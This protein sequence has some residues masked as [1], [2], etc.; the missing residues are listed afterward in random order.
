MT[1]AACAADAHR[2]RDAYRLVDAVGPLGAYVVGPAVGEPDPT[3]LEW[4][5]TPWP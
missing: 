1:C 4:A 5:L 2:M 3:V